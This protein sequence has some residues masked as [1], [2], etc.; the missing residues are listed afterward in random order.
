MAQSILSSTVS[1]PLPGI[2]Q[3]QHMCCHT[4][5]TETAGTRF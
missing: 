4:F 3:L 2:L 1:E 5:E